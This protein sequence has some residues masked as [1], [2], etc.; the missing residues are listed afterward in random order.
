M[1]T[2]RAATCCT[3]VADVAD[4]LNGAV[5]RSR[6][7]LHFSALVSLVIAF[8]SVRLGGWRVVLKL[9][10]LVILYSL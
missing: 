5:N 1:N 9:V 8:E 6:L 3:F 2:R 7:G 4:K 10:F